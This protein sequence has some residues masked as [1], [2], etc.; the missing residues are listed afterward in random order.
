MNDL[1]QK[2]NILTGTVT[3]IT[4]YGIF[5]SLDENKSGLIHIS[6]IS[7]RFVKYIHK[8]VTM[9]ELI[10]VE[11][12]GLDNKN[13]YRLSI[14]NIDYRIMKNKKSKITETPSG[15]KNLAIHLDKWIEN[16]QN[17]EEIQKKD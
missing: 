12:V 1:Y 6:E 16:W 2:G 7:D 4:N 14:K 17:S 15:F 8:F 11:I 10:R 13:H 9:G 5:V 3:G